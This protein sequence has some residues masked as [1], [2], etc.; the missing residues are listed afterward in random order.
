MSHQLAHSRTR[1]KLGVANKRQSS[2]HVGAATK[3]SITATA[4]M[5]GGAALGGIAMYQGHIMTGAALMAG[6]LIGG[7]YLEGKDA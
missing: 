3:S 2:V 6:G 4:V 5:L 7:S 1:L